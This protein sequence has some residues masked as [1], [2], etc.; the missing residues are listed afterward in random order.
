ME[1]C[2]R[3]NLLLSAPPFS[4]GRQPAR[5]FWCKRP[6]LAVNAILLGSLRVNPGLATVSP[7]YDQGFTSFLA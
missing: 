2:P 3:C 1:G 6:F 5:R 4:N 7:W